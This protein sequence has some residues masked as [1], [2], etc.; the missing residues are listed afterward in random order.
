MTR[1]LLSLILMTAV[2]AGAQAAEPAAKPS[3]EKPKAQQSE[4]FSGSLFN[5]LRS[6]SGM[7][8]KQN[9][10]KEGPRQTT[11][12]GIRGAETTTTL[13][14]PYWKDD[15][16]DDPAFQKELNEYSA[17]QSLLEQEKL[18]EAEGALNTFIKQYPDSALQPNARFA[19]A[20]NYAAQGKQKEGKSGFE[21]FVKAYPNHPLV[22]DAQKILG[23]MK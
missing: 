1:K 8:P 17:A 20:L 9:G 16:S 15:K 19:L 18:T 11:T 4:R 10:S 7:L 23:E 14:N 3:E 2:A 5:A 22:A 12:M 6:L 13:M 21:Q